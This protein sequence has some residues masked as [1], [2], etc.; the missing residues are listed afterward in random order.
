[1][2]DHSMISYLKTIFINQGRIKRGAIRSLRTT[3][4]SASE[5][6]RVYFCA[7]TVAR[8]ELPWATETISSKRRQRIWETAKVTKCWLAV[9]SHGQAF[10]MSQWANIEMIAFFLVRYGRERG[11]SQRHDSSQ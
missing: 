7:I 11:V 6:S 1:M 10:D 2:N 3:A 4:R 5:S 9:G 8:R